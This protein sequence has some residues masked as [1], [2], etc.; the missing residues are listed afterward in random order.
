MKNLPIARE[1]NV[2]V[3]WRD[4][5]DGRV[6]ESRVMTVT[7]CTACQA[8]QTAAVLA[9]GQATADFAAGL[10]PREVASVNVLSPEEMEELAELGAC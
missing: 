2:L 5:L 7:A 8:I 6:G 3:G 10:I 9:S 1:F 4:P